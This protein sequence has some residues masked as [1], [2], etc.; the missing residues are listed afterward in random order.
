MRMIL[1][2]AMIAGLAS[3]AVADDVNFS[4]TN[5]TGADLTEFYATP[6]GHENWEQNLLGMPALAAG[7]VAQVTIVNAQGC[8]YDLRMV[9]A[10]GDVLEG[11]SN[12]C[13][14]TDY[15]IQ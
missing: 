9:F 1:S 7:R 14:T 11:A 10:D 13:E 6:V 8:D 5:M 15:T 12:I 3:P 4:L 2:V